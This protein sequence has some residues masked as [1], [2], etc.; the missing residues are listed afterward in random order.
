[1]TSL[2]AKI[3][4]ENTRIKDCVIGDGKKGYTVWFKVGPQEF[5]VHVADTKK[6]ALWMQGRLAEAIY[7]LVTSS[8][9][10]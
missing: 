6:E 7:R 8:V 5:C 9:T 4:K 2:Y 3:K 1:M 10:S